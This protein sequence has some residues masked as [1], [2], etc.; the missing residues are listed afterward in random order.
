MKRIYLFGLMAVAASAIVI[1]AADPA[2]AEGERRAGGG[3]NAIFAAL[4]A[5]G[6]GVIDAAEIANAPAALKKLDKNGDGKLTREE[7]RPAGG[8]R[9]GDTN[10]NGNGGRRRRDQNSGAGA[11]STTK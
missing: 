10:G 5:N 9:G 1:K 8:R 2:P 11:S 6:D 3:T 4:D 7:L